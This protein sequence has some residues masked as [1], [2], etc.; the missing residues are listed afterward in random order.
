[1]VEFDLSMF[2]YMN[3]GNLGNTLSTQFG[4]PG[5]IFGMTSEE[6]RDMPSSVLRDLLDILEDARNK[7]DAIEKEVYKKAMIDAGIFEIDTEE[8]TFEFISDTSRY[9]LD[10]DSEN[11]IGDL[12]AFI[13]AVDNA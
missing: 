1:V 10:R 13:E 7:A 2:M 9:G 4:V 5:P 3:R 11:L 12:Q 6:F 8:G